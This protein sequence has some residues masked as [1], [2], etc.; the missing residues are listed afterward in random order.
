MYDN[1][2]ADCRTNA[3]GGTIICRLCV[4]ED[5]VGDESYLKQDEV[6]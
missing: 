4:E 2:C 1:V 3:D 5:T 6:C